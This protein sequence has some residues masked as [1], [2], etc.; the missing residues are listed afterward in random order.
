MPENKRHRGGGIANPSTVDKP[1]M[2]IVALSCRSNVETLS[3][4][5]PPLVAVRSAYHRLRLPLHSQCFL[6]EALLIFLRF[7]LSLVESSSLLEA[8]LIFWLDLCLRFTSLLL[9]VH[10][11]VE[12]LKPF[13]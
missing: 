7:S 5:K 3:D 11:L 6:V 4:L 9:W 2:K 1:K 8:L 10:F 12:G 13:L